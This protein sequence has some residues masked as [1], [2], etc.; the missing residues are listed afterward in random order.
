[1]KIASVN[2]LPQFVGRSTFIDD[3]SYRKAL[4]LGLKKKFDLDCKIEALNSVATPRELNGFIKNLKPFQY[5]VGDDF[6]AN[7]HLHT[8]AS[9]GSLTPKEFL[10]KCVGWANRMFRL[11]KSK[12]GLPPFM[13]A[14]TDHDRVKSVQEV[15]AL[16]SQEPERY[17]NF[18]FVTGC[19]FMFTGYEGDAYPAFEAVG[20]GFNPFAE[21]LEPLMKGFGSDNKVEDIKKV[22]DAGGVLSYAHP[23]VNPDKLTEHFF[24]F[25]VANGVN[26]V[27]G[28]YQYN[29]WDKEYVNAGK[30]IVEKLAKKFNMF[31]TGGTDSHRKTIF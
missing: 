29:H 13:C 11:G 28:N 2:N 3:V 8:K 19:E 21:E 26:G 17:K 23:L 4:Q 1:M 18:K 16:I 10:S 27:E 5:V 6:R 31:L 7:F 9:D 12:D 20:L 30:P 25:L 24:S 15:V 22:L 14:I